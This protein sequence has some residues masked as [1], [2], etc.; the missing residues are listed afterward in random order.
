MREGEKRT[1]ETI[2]CAPDPNLLE[3]MRSFGYSLNTA[4]ADIIDNSISAGAHTIRILFSGTQPNPYIA[5]VDDGSGM[6]CETAQKAMQL[7]GTGTTLSRNE[8]DLGRFGLGLKTASFSQ[9]RQLTVVS[10]QRAE[11]TTLRWD[12]DTVAQS[13][14]WALESLDAEET[15]QSSWWQAGAS[16]FV[17]GDEAVDCLNGNVG[18]LDIGVDTV[19]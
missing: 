11:I 6:D 18:S 7:A 9:A 12:L 15:R 19:R 14:Q 1:M 4:A 17:H 8:N 10:K 3:S 5:I 13:Q 2:E 16:E